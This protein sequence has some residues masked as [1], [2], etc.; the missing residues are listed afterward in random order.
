[1]SSSLIDVSA[2]EASFCNQP[3]AYKT[4]LRPV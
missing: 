1:M 3:D 2:G 4:T